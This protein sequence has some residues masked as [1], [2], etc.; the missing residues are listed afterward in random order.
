VLKRE[1]EAITSKSSVNMEATQ[2]P[3]RSQESPSPRY[4]PGLGP[5]NDE[6]VSISHQLSWIES[7]WFIYR[8]HTRR[9]LKIRMSENVMNPLSLP[10]TLL[11]LKPTRERSQQHQRR[12]LP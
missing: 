7:L 2:Q 4:P 6:T 5:G 3:R 12:H 11:S 1:L 8:P 9:H 10:L